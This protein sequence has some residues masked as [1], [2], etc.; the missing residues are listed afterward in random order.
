MSGR[1]AIRDVSPCTCQPAAATGATCARRLSPAR[2]PRCSVAEGVPVGRGYLN[3]AKE[4]TVR[5]RSTGGKAYL[6]V[7]G[8]TVGGHSLGVRV[9]DSRRR[10]PCHARHARR[11]S[12]S[13]EET[14]WIPHAG[15]TIEVDEFLGE[16]ACLVVAEVELKSEGQTFDK[17]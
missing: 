10:R 8:L 7:K 16:N 17:P 13:R 6:T 11:A 5:V 2:S 4:R 14:L 15:F 9:R 3:S 1:A 12:D